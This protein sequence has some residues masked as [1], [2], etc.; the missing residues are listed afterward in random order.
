MFAQVIDGRTNDRAALRRRFDAWASEVEP[1]AV[2]FEGS[3]VVC[4]D[5]GRFI[6][7]ARFESADAAR[8]N[9]E[10][11]EQDA[12]WRETEPLVESEARFRESDDIELVFGGGSDDAGFV[13]VLETQPRDRKHLL[14]LERS[15]VDE[16]KAHRPELLG[17]VRIWHG[18]GSATEVV[19]FT[20]EAEAREG[21]SKDVPTE[22]ADA[23]AEYER[24][25]DPVEF[26][27]TA[28]PWMISA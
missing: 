12:W 17:L 15:F 1:G 21:E 16:M 5:D 26:V 20:S 10:R 25:L 9:S 7:V 3:T 28:D 8:R 11:P 2:G 27:D 24:L 22:H 13:Q 23:V 18:P 19:Y 4:G 14:S 6:V